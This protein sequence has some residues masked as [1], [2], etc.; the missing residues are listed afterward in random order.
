ME[1]LASLGCIGEAG[2]GTHV[3]P[4]MHLLHRIGVCT[5]SNALGT[6]LS[7]EGVHLVP[8]AVSVGGVFSP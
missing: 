8:P 1:S 4:F 2:D 6:L 5:G 7:L 3:L